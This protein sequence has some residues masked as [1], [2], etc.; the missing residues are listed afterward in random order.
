MEPVG[1]Q[2]VMIG[3][4]DSNKDGSYLTSTCAL[5]QASIALAQVTRE[6]G[7]RLQ[8]FHGRGGTTARES[9]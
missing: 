3:Y 2:E 6:A 1:I 4:S 5:H 8:L 7:L 9:T